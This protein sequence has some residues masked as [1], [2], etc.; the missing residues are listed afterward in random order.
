[1]NEVHPIRRGGASDLLPALNVWRAAE[2]AR[3]NGGTISPE[4]GERVRN[5]MENPDAFFFVA[6]GEG[7]I[8]GMAVGMQGLAEDGAGPPIE[9]LCHI[10]AVFVVPDH[11]G[12]GI[13]GSLVDTVLTEARARGYGL[14]QLWTHADNTRAQTLYERH[15]FHPTGRQKP[16]EH[17]ETIVHYERAL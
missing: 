9:D 10:G 16:D 8:V 13:G 4:H 2:E 1:M 5:H 7:K 3:R 11:W 15:G 6:E 12:K 14:A 17:N